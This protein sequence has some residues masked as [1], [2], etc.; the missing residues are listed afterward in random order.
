MPKQR[1]LKWR[2]FEIL[3][4]HNNPGKNSWELGILLG[5]I[6]QFPRLPIYRLK[7]DQALSNCKGRGNRHSPVLCIPRKPGLTAAVGT[8]RTPVGISGG[9]YSWI[10]FLV[11]SL[12]HCAILSLSHFPISH[13][14]VVQFSQLLRILLALNLLVSLAVGV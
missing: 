14:K 8:A 11:T 5:T 3:A 1:F 6:G 4:T 9:A 2:L 10:D 7:I 12:H 13:S